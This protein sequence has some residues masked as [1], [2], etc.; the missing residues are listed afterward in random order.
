MLVVSCLLSAFALF[1]IFL[2]MVVANCIG[3]LRQLAPYGA[4]LFIT[5][6]VNADT[7]VEKVVVRVCPHICVEPQ[8][9]SCAISTLDLLTEAAGRLHVIASSGPHKWAGQLWSP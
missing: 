5:L 4:N 1:F 6:S 2:G 8:F 9:Q 3:Y 7:A